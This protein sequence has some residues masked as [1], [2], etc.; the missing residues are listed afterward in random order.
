MNKYSK[1]SQKNIIRIDY[2]FCYIMPK[3]LL[4]NYT[5]LQTLLFKKISYFEFHIG[6]IYFE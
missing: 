5:S 1:S 3:Y 4:R 6:M 2:I